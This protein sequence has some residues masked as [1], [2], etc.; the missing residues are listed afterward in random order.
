[1]AQWTAFLIS[2]VYKTS[3]ALDI[4]DALEANGV[5]VNCAL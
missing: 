1:M 4:K 3:D 5:D 2:V